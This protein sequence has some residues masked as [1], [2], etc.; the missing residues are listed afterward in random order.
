MFYFRDVTGVEFNSG[1]VTGVLEVLTASYNGT[2]NKDFWR[3]TRQSRNADSNDPYTL[4]NTL[5]LSKVE[6]NNALDNI[7]ELRQRIARSK[8]QVVLAPSAQ[9]LPSTSTA[10]LGDE[11][12]KL[13]ELHKAGV[14]SDDEFQSAKKRLLG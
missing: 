11:L 3:G 5:P 7:K 13:S 6:Y 4:S 1:M 9:Q 14:L 2:A 10:S 8:E 12:M